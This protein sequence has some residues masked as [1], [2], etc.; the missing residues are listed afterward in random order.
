MTFLP[1]IVIAFGFVFTLVPGATPKRPVSG[2]TARSVPS[3]PIRI[4]QMSSPTVSTFQPG[5]LGT[6]IARFVFPQAEGNPPVT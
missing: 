6:I 4:Q 3:G 2:L 5:R 1:S